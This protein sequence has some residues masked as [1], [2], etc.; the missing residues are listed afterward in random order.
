MGTKEARVL[1]L[2]VEQLQA[3][4]I[5]LALPINFLYLCLP[6]FVYACRIQHKFLSLRSSPALLV[7]VV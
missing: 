7:P 2:H 6:P 1:H 5:P 4:F 3:T